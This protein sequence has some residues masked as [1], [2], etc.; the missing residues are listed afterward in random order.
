[1]MTQREPLA[2]VTETPLFIVIGPVELPLEPVG[3]E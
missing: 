3:I 1:M 2:T